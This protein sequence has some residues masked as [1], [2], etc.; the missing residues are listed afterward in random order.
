MTTTRNRLLP[1]TEALQSYV[2]AHGVR[3]HPVLAE[4]RRATDDV[5]H[6]GMQIGQDQGAF[7]A[8]LVKL[9]GARR[10]IEV[11]VYTGYSSLAVALAL[12]SDG[13]IIA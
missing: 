6:A 7:M 8:L 9:L 3:E 4:L 11:G 1:F 2:V 12:P 10:T 13:K 5:P